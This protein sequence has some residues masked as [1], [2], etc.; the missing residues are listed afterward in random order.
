[1]NRQPQRLGESMG[2]SEASASASASAAPRLGDLPKVPQLILTFT[3]DIIKLICAVDE[4]LGIGIETNYIE[5]EDEK[6]R[7]LVNN[8]Y[9]ILSL[10][11]LLV[12]L[13][14][15]LL[16]LEARMNYLADTLEQLVTNENSIKVCELIEREAT[17]KEQLLHDYELR[18]VDGIIC[19]VTVRIPSKDY[20]V[21]Q[22]KTS[23]ITSEVR[24][25][26]FRKLKLRKI[27]VEKAIILL[28]KFMMKTNFEEVLDSREVVKA[29]QQADLISSLNSVISR[30][31]NSN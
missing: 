8:S 5:H 4:E 10:R 29:R 21:Y 11:T 30:E 14:E 27:L 17:G 3:E 26:Y 20:L 22:K 15:I 31:S 7:F 24:T 13:K 9:N 23:S 12:V 28:K 1:M 25:Y 2:N 19:K 18:L 16:C 6:R